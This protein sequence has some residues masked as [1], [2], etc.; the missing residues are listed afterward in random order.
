MQD[1]G[2]RGLPTVFRERGYRFFFDSNEGS[3]REPIHVHVEK[4]AAAAKFWIEPIIALEESFGFSS[5]QLR[6]IVI[7]QNEERIRNAWHD[8]FGG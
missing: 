1:H 2:E 3:P 6:E 4:G 8:F 5:A 7:R